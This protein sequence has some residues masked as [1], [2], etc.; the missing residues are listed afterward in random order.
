MKREK[1]GKMNLNYVIGGGTISY[2]IKKMLITKNDI[3]EI[4]LNRSSYIEAIETVHTLKEEGIVTCKIDNNLED[5][6]VL[7][8]CNDE[9]V[10][11]AQ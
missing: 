7:F 11:E 6:N 5:N 2:N 8:F 4:I 1:Y 9:L 3:N 10:G